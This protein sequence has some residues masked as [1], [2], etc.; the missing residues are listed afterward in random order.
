MTEITLFC[1]LWRRNDEGAWCQVIKVNGKEVLWPD[2]DLDPFLDEIVRLRAAGD[3]LAEVADE[4]PELVATWQ[5]AR[6][7]S[8]PTHKERPMTTDDILG[9]DIVERLRKAL[10]EMISDN[11]HTIAILGLDERF[12]V[13]LALAAILRGDV[14][15]DDNDG[16]ITDPVRAL[17]FGALMGDGPWWIGA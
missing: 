15:P 10:V 12:D 8:N 9:E 7:E 3:A 13:D 6:R 1:G 11:R 5:E 17:A 4:W 14:E 16:A 2:A